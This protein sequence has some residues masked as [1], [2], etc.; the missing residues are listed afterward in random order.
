MQ[1]VIPT[2][3]TGRLLLRPRTMGDYADCLA[4]D[5]DPEVMRYVGGLPTSM[6]EHAI[7]LTDRITKAYPPGLGYWSVF[8]KVSPEQSSAGCCWCLSIRTTLHRTW[9]SAGGW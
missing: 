1:M 5:G 3:E 8:P 7:I 2:I 4:M 9:R 6:E